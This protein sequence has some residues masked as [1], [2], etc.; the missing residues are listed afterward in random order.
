MENTRDLKCEDVRENFKSWHY[1]E[2]L[3]KKMV[4]KVPTKN[5]A[6]KD[7]FCKEKGCQKPRYWEEIYR[8]KRLTW[9]RNVG[10]SPVLQARNGVRV[11]PCRTKR[12][13]EESKRGRS[14]LF[15][16]VSA[17]LF[18]PFW[19]FKVTNANFNYIDILVCCGKDE[20]GEKLVIF[21]GTYLWLFRSLVLCIVEMNSGWNSSHMRRSWVCRGGG[22]GVLLF[23]GQSQ[24]DRGQRGSKIK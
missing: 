2:Y 1:W 15:S 8:N 21:W 23:T 7:T 10:V 9:Q 13:T 16:A 12:K 11:D 17:D 22:G 5:S 14:S 6:R 18:K 20:N 3:S 4:P 24:S 19:N